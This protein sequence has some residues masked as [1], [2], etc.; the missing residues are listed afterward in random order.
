MQITFKDNPTNIES[1]LP[2]ILSYRVIESVQD[3]LGPQPMVLVGVCLSL[4]GFDGGLGSQNPR[5]VLLGLLLETLRANFWAGHG[6]GLGGRSVSTVVEQVVGV[7]KDEDQLRLSESRRW[8][9]IAI[10]AKG[11]VRFGGKNGVGGGDQRWWGNGITLRGGGD[12]CVW[13]KDWLNFKNILN[14]RL[15]SISPPHLKNKSYWPL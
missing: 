5:Q 14:Y 9:F 3:S 11:R 1:G 10:G 2:P 8:R 7:K 13:I 12:L 15:L 4:N 6:G